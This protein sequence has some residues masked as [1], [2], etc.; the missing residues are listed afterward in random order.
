MIRATVC[1]AFLISIFPTTGEGFQSIE[2]D[3]LAYEGDVLPVTEDPLNPNLV[4]WIYQDEDG[5]AAV[6]DLTGVTAEGGFLQV[7][8]VV[9]YNGHFLTPPIIEK[10]GDETG[11][12][13][14]IRIQVLKNNAIL[15]IHDATGFVNLEL[16]PHSL[17]QYQTNAGGVTVGEDL[18][19]NPVRVRLLYQKGR[20]QVYVESPFGS[21]GPSVD[22]SLTP[23]PD[24]HFESR[25]RIGPNET[26]SPGA[27]Y[28][29]DYLRVARGIIPPPTGTTPIFD[30]VLRRPVRIGFNMVVLPNGE[31]ERFSTERSVEGVFLTSDRSDSHGISW[32]IPQ[33]LVQLPEVDWRAILALLDRENEVH[34]FFMVTRDDVGRPAVNRFIDLWHMRSEGGRTEWSIPQRIYAGYVGSIHGAIQADSG[35][36]VFPFGKWIGG[37]TCGPPTGCNATVALYSDDL[38]ETWTLSE[39]ELVSPVYEGYNGINYGAIEPTLTQFED[40]RFWMLMRTQTGYLYESFSQDGEQWE[41]ATPSQFYSSNSPSSVLR[42][43]GGR[44]LVAWNGCEVPPRLDGDE[45]DGGRDIL[46]AAVSL[47]GGSTFHGFREIYRDPFRNESPPV[48]GD[49]GTAYPRLYDPRDDLVFATAGQGANRRALIRFDP[50]WLLETHAESD[51]STGLEEWT[52]FKE[53]GPNSGRWRDRTQGAVLANL[54]AKE[55]ATGPVLHVRKPD[56][57]SPDGAVWNFPMGRTGQLELRIRFNQD[58]GGG[59]IALTDRFF[60]PTDSEGEERAPLRLDIDEEGQLSNGFRFA[61]ERWRLLRFEWNLDKRECDIFVDNMLV[62]RLSLQGDS[63]G[64]NYL[65]LRST[66]KTVDP[67]GFYVDWVKMRSKENETTSSW[68]LR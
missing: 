8:N 58:H 51:F 59:C 43:R 42:L 17:T 26:T 52:V 63:Q 38:G 12:T 28:R 21:F 64:L 11:Y 37:Q 39:S 48:Q 62:E 46:H 22:Q 1:L 53:F 20:V 41:E 19:S 4:D 32:S 16:R 33:R 50:N 15:Q 66:A 5:N 65:R 13:I 24:D 45:I 67:N 61:S 7:E 2:G 54:S 56:T 18:S 3:L 23:V 35:R 31:W 27:T 49:R 34:L 6:H 36:V 55:E 30:P 10:F 29:V 44:I 9:R 14:E 68:R 40:G 60:N 25:I 57:H 47:D